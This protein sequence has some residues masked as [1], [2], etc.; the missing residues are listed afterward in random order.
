MSTPGF[1]VTF[2][3]VQRYDWQNVP[4]KLDSQERRYNPPSYFFFPKAAE[5]REAGDEVGERVFRFLGA[6]TSLMPSFDSKETPFRPKIIEATRRSS[7]LEDFSDEDRAVLAQLVAVTKDSEIKARFADVAAVLKFDHTLVREAVGAYLATAR[8]RE[9]CDNWPGFISNPE[10]AAQLAWKLGRNSQPFSDVMLYVEELVAKFSTSDEGLCCARL[11]ELM[12]QFGHGDATAYAQIAETLA[13]RAET[14]AKP[15]FALSYWE[16]ASGWYR[17]AKRDSDEQRCAIRAAETYVL[18]AEAALKRPQPS[19]MASAG[20]LAKAV[21]A[22]RRSNAPKERVEEVHRLQLERAKRTKDEMKTFSHEVRIAEVQAGA[23]KHVEGYDLRTAVCRLAV[24]ATPID[25][26]KHRVDVEQLAKDHP[27]SFLF[28]ASTVDREGRVIGH[29]PSLL[30][31]DPTQYEAALW[32]EMIHQAS[33]TNWPFRVQA[34][35][36]P[37]RLQIWQEH[38]PSLRDLY[39]LV[40]NNPFIPPGHEHSFAR[41]FHA[42]FEEDWHAAAYFLVPQVE[43][44][45]RYVLDGRGVIT[46]KL[47]GKRIQEVRTIEK[48]LL[49]PETID[50]LGEEHVFELR[51][52]LTEEFGSNLRH[53]LA[54]GLLADG[55]CYTHAT[56]HLWWILLRLCVYPILPPSFLADS[57]DTEP[58]PDDDEST[59]KS[60]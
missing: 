24:G 8:A 25:P 1:G 43:N 29:R 14:N 17:R 42:G 35:I 12:Q 57:P 36:G 16:L 39:F 28:S 15:H 26:K 11:M 50:A 33:T 56:E 2:E 27:F 40:T 46:S 20:H 45:I 38:H 54:H 59:R 60:D 3:E 21:E 10:R 52:I 19:Y 4:P 49:M 18:E 55:D 6:V 37:A 47:D 7:A 13:E 31:T 9:S 34:F 41:G 51:G 32:A 5:L 30:T 58:R 48:L 44:S 53:R 23:R 22:L